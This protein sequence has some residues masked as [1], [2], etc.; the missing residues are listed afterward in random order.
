MALDTYA[1]LTVSELR[2]YL[3]LAEDEPQSDGFSIYHDQSASATAATV[4][5][6]D[7]TL[8]LT[9]TGGANAGT[10]TFTLAAGASD[11]LA[12]LTAQITALAKGW[13]VILLAPSATVSTLLV[14]KPVA[15]AYGTS[16][17]LRLLYVN[18][19]A[20]ENIINRASDIVETYLDRKILTR[21]YVE[22]YDAHGSDVMM[23]RQYPATA[24]NRMAWGKATALR[25]TG[26]VATDLRASVEVQDTFVNLKRWDSSGTLTT[27]T[28]D[29]TTSTTT[30][31]LAA[32]IGLIAGFDAE[33]V[34]NVIPTEL[35][36]MGGQDVLNRT[37]D[38]YY[39]DQGD[40]E[41]RVDEERGEIVIVNAPWWG[42]CG[43]EWC[44]GPPTPRGRQRVLVDYTAGYATVPD[45]IKQAT[46][47]V[48]AQL[49]ASAGQDLSLQSESLGDYS[50]TS[51]GGISIAQAFTGALDSR[52]HMW[53]RI[54]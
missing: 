10:D 35:F 53:R 45:D 21:A 13:Q 30:E 1:L 22:W 19:V 47:E 11:T 49:N 6:T 3:D 51:G 14:P 40:I 50:Y 9:I 33:S 2:E 32:A 52:L 5:V 39:P 48:A 27:T 7:T 18:V 12:E 37:V 24:V 23:L 4:T 42:W 15:S 31:Q 36:R 25:V 20:L 29:Y 44:D 41:Y 17:T 46:L 28:H 26:A 54:R 8:V 34:V 38:L 43:D 16:N